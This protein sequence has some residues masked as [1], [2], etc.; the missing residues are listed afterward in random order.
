MVETKVTR[1]RV[2]PYYVILGSVLSTV[3]G[4]LALKS[5]QY[6]RKVL[7]QPYLVSRAIYRDASEFDT[8]EARAL[9]IAIQNLRSGIERRHLLN[10]ENKLVLDAGWRNFREP[11]ARDF[12]FASFGLLALRE[13]QV[14]REALE[15][16]LIHQRS[17]GQ[18]PVKIHSTG[19][20]ER[21]LH[22]LFKREQ[23]TDIPLRPKYITGHR[24]VSMDG[25]ALLVIA[26]LNYARLAADH[27]FAKAH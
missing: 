7:R 18:F 12:G 11:W 25:N 26:N 3:L 4:V 5:V 15:A 20:L 13:F 24:T 16:F 9:S 27:E 21:Y 14:T 2:N 6:L 22:S 17:S 1:K 10:G 23:P 8:P 19:G